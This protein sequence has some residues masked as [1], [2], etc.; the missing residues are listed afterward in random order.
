MSLLEES[1]SSENTDQYIN[2]VPKS[3]TRLSTD[4]YKRP[5]LTYTDKLT[6]DEINNKLDDYIEVK[7]GFKSVPEGTH[8]RYFSKV[9]KTYKFRVGG[10]LINKKGL[11][12][13]IVLSN[14]KK[15]WSVQMKDTIFFKKISILEIKRVYIEELENKDKLLKYKDDIIQKQGQRINDLV[16][17]VN[18]L[19][20]EVKNKKR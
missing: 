2:S 5:I 12:D 1:E 7:D 13:Y 6:R 8:I 20:K 4:S 3:E 14:G 9:N 18:Q 16:A 15:S 10:T 11:P 19:K 17:L